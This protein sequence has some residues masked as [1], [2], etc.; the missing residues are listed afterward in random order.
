MNAI[1]CRLHH[2]YNSYY[3]NVLQSSNDSTKTIDLPYLMVYKGNDICSFM[4]CVF[5]MIEYFYSL[6]KP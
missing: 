4:F 1:T 2:N 3:G 5:E 6:E